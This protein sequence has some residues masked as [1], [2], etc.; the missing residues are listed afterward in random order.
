MSQDLVFAGFTEGKCYDFRPTFKVLRQSEHGYTPQR[1]PAWCDRILWKSVHGFGVKQTE[2]KAAESIITS[3][4]KP[5]Y[6][7]FDVAPLDYVPG[8]DSIL[9]KCTLHVTSLTGVGVRL[10]AS[11]KS[12]ASPLIKFY[13]SVLKENKETTVLHNRRSSIMSQAPNLSQPNSRRQSLLDGPAS[14]ALATTGSKVAKQRRSSIMV[15][16]KAL[17]SLKWNDANVPVLQLAHNVPA[18]IAQ[19]YLFFTMF[20][21]KISKEK[22]AEG[23]LSLAKLAEEAEPAFLEARSKA[24]KAAA[25]AKA[26]AAAETEEK[27]KKKGDGDGGDGDDEDGDD[28]GESV[29]G[30]VTGLKVCV[31]VPF[32]VD[33]Q[34]HGQ[35]AGKLTGIVSLKWHA[36]E[37]QFERRLVR[38]GTVQLLK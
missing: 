27:K 11:N 23:V 32:E 12:K 37:E 17:E 6:G 13:G 33:L 4:H 8:N 25:D 15:M 9:G 3:D 26:A 21:S 19:H 20:D 18:R 5:V 28:V 34:R 35:G 2:F 38:K 24:I 22:L 1:S 29:G 7:C 36:P 31:D 10:I 14:P 30:L 16:S